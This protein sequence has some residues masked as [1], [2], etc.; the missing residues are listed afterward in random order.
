[1]TRTLREAS[2]VADKRLTSWAQSPISEENAV[3]GPVSD[4]AL[5]FVGLVDFAEGAAYINMSAQQ[6]V[7]LVSKGNDLEEILTGM[8]LRA[9]LVGLLV[10]AS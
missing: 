4:M 9:L 3:R 10:E 7:E 2:A 8:I 6:T 5:L 1:M